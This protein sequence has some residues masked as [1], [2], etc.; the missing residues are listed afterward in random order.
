MKSYNTRW[1]ICSGRWQHS[2]CFETHLKHEFH[3]IVYGIHFR[4]LNIAKYK[5]SGIHLQFNSL[6]LRKLPDLPIIDVLQQ[7]S[8]LFSFYAFNCRI[9]NIAK[10]T[11]HTMLLPRRP[12][13]SDMFSIFKQSWHLKCKLCVANG[14]HFWH[15]N[16]LV[17]VSKLLRQKM[18]RFEEE[19]NPQYSDSCGIL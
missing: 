4:L 16:V 6:P 9:L 12:Q 18:F 19:S 8:N 5:G 17:K 1:L 3:D 7:I 13:S 2:N 15:T 10:K 11:K 14:I